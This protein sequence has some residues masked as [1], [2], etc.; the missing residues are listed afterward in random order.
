M[1]KNER[2]LARVPLFA[3]LSPAELHDLA[4]RLR[5]VE[6]PSEAVLFREG[7]PGN[8]FYIVLDGQIDVIKALGT[9]DERLVGICEP[10]DFYGEASLFSRN[11]Q[12]TASVRTHGPTRLMEL[13]RADLDALLHRQPL[14]AYEMIQVLTTRLTDAHNAAIR[15]LQEKNSQL[16]QAYEALK[17]AQAQIIE[18]EKLERELQVAYDIQMSILPAAL[19]HLDGFDF[20]ARI[21]PARSV[22]GDLFDFIPLGDDTLGIVVGDVT[23]KGVPAAIFMAQAHALLRAEAGIAVLPRDV[24]LRVNDHLLDMNARGLF[25]TVLYGLLNRVTGEF[26]YARAAHDLPL[27]CTTRGEVIQAPQRTGQPLGIFA[28]PQI[29][30]QTLAIPPGGTL[31][32]YTD[33]V[34]DARD[35]DGVAFGVDR[36]KSALGNC[37]GLAAQHTCDHL[38]QAVLPHRDGGSQDDDVTL[39]AVHS[40]R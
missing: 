40:Q 27:V 19:P 21:E 30:E 17:A 5:L 32:I 10:G 36:L 35:S 38:L 18:K 25:V 3:S 20:G 33:G 31:L 1:N 14:L 11:G 34:T 9:P 16:T 23:D 26:A 7:D 37:A 29:D 13:T 15:D 2:I 28:D 22:G 39:V 8:N 4:A 24:L 6:E 12:R